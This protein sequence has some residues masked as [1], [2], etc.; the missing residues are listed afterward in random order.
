MGGE[1]AAAPAAASAKGAVEALLGE[2]GRPAVEMM[3]RVSAY[4]ATKS[5]GRA[6]T[7]PKVWMVV[8]WAEPVEVMVGARVV[9]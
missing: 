8:W 1:A 6:D 9:G 2:D 5:W 3:E 7:A 4:P